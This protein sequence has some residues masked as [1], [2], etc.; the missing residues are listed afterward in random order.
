M[1]TSDDTILDY[2]VTLSG[3]SLGITYYYQVV[4][5]YSNFTIKSSVGNFTTS[6]LGKFIPLCTYLW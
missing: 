2:S 4:A 3:L 6:E 1:S 5:T